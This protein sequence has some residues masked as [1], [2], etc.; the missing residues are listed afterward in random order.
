MKSIIKFTVLVVLLT[1]CIVYPRQTSA[2]ES[3]VSFQ[4]FY[5]QLSPYGEWVNDEHYGYVWFPDV[6]ADFVPY[7]TDGRWILTDYGWTWASDYDWSWAAFH[8][9]RW[10]L[11]DSY[12]WFWIP[13][14]EWGPAWVNW[15]QADGYY[16][17]SPMEPGMSLSMSYGTDYE[18]YNQHW[19]FV[20]DR[21][22][23]RSNIHNYYI[24]RSEQDRI[25]RNSIVIKNTYHDNYRHTTYAS[26][27]SRIEVQRVVGRTINPVVIQENNKP[28]QVLNNGQLR[29]YRPQITT[30]GRKPVPT[31]VSNMNEIR[32]S[33]RSGASTQPRNVTPANNNPVRQPTTGNQQ[34]NNTAP[35]QQRDGNQR[36]NNQQNQPTRTF[37]PANPGSSTPATQPQRTNPSNNDRQVR[38]N[39]GITPRNNN[40]QPMNQRNVSPQNNTVQP[41]QQQNTNQQNNTVQPV[42]Q[43]YV[44]PQNN[45][46]Q[47]NQ[48]R[49]VNPQNNNAQP[50]EQRNVSP[51]NNTVQPYQQRNVTPQ[52]NNVQPNQQR[53]ETPQNNT[54]QPN[55]QRN[56]N[57]QNNNLMQQ[58]N[59]NQGQRQAAPGD[60][61]NKPQPN[62]PIRVNQSVTKGSRQPQ[63]QVKPQKQIEKPVEVKPETDKKH[64]D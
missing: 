63:K 18:S 2:Q 57:T 36:N 43:R 37:V 27:P 47:P 56:V 48:Q 52:N 5:D 53:N 50:N 16:G 61:Q 8:Y 44:A 21:D 41:Y 31:R 51:Q 20:R 39:D 3:N 33:Q 12:G 30:N 29:I 45:T 11:N 25:G 38:P 60:I 58:N 17:W 9:G 19:M 32:H 22:I 42:Q 15:R 6:N 35:A 26:G 1:S 54:V 13:D 28:G 10:G 62:Q 14:N 64:T 7:S 4:V 23:E 46:V 59:N 34:L 55:Q 24:E 49:N 40:Q